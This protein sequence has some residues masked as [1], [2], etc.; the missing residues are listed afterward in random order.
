MA[1][2]SDNTQ[3]DIAFAAGRARKL[4]HSEHG[5]GIPVRGAAA[6]GAMA[7]RVRAGTLLVSTCMTGCA[8][9]ACSS[10]EGFG[11]ALVAEQLEATARRR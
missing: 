6:R 11:Q 8:S 4:E 10:R 9:N 2:E 5:A 1:V 7:G 3:P